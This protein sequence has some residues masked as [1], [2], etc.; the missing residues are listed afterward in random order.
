MVDLHPKIAKW[1]KSI[2][3]TDKKEVLEQMRKEASKLANNGN[4][5]LLGH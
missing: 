3:D 5:L 4:C 2:N 1:T